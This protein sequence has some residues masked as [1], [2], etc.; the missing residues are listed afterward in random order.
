[1]ENRGVLG[2]DTWDPHPHTHQNHA[3]GWV[4]IRS[5]N[6]VL[7]L[8]VRFCLK[9]VTWP[10]HRCIDEGC[11]DDVQVH[12]TCVSMYLHLYRLYLIVTN[13]EIP[14]GEYPMNLQPHQS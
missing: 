6:S 10:S 13:L 7:V 8:D 11:N 1:M 14:H 4:P 12:D 5:S 2:S 9:F 3:V